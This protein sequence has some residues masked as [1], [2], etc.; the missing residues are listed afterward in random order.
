MGLVQVNVIDSFLWL[1][2]VGVSKD[3]G[4]RVDGLR[5]RVNIGW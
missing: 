4:A 2:L 3:K 5:M 1:D